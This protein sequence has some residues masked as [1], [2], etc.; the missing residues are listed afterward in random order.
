M[1]ELLS[2]NT[3]DLKKNL[4]KI[5]Q[6]KIKSDKDERNSTNNKN[7]NDRLNIILSVIERIYEIFEY[8]FLS[9]KPSDQQQQ[10]DQQQQQ[11]NQNLR[12]WV[13]SMDDYTNLK[14]EFDKKQKKDFAYN[15]DSHQFNL[16]DINNYLIS[17]NNRKTT[18]DDAKTFLKNDI[19]NEMQKIIKTNPRNQIKEKNIMLNAYKHV[20]QV[21]APLLKSDNEQSNPKTQESDD[22]Q[23]DTTDTPDLET[24][25]SAAQ[26]EHSAKGFK[27]QTPSELLSRLPI[28]LAQLNAGNNYE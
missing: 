24:E 15:A 22:K 2:Q 27:I 19:A 25:E 8:K 4:D 28:S 14:K 3:Q 20:A 16:K 7:E 9:D 1:S 18:K 11:Q 5:K 23:P 10:L 26:E 17:V 12:L 21:F 6:Q 13:T